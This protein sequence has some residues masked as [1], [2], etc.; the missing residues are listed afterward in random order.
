[1]P[2]RS[3]LASR[4]VPK[5][6]ISSIWRRE[7]VRY[8]LMWRNV[9][10]G[11]RLG[12]R[13]GTVGLGI[14][15]RFVSV[16]ETAVGRIHGAIVGVLGL[17]SVAPLTLA[18]QRRMPDRTAVDASYATIGQAFPVS[19]D[20]VGILAE[21]PLRPDEIVV[22]LFIAGS[23]GVSPDAVASLRS[24]GTRWARILRTHSVGAGALRVPFPEGTML[25]PIEETYRTFSETPRA[26]WARIDLSDEAAIAL[27]N[28]RI[29][30]R[31]VGVTVGRV[32][33]TWDGEG[34]FVLVHQRITR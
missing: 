29:L 34:G 24:S 5:G 15:W 32:L 23:A 9:G 17:M 7:L 27:V 30:A 1:M 21:W 28:I 16:E 33:R 2:V 4:V 8:A 10:L 6:E 14:G 20:E 13:V 22:V 26:S 18:A 3:D 11:G 31:Q 12:G 25:G 19:T